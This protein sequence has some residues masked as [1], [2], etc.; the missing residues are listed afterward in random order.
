ME[1]KYTL[2]E[3][4]YL[5]FNLFHIKNS[6]TAAKSLKMQRFIT[7][8]VYIVLAFVFSKM[9][10][11]PLLYTLIPFAIVGVLWIIFYPK[12][13]YRVVVRQTKKMI[14]EGKNEGLLGSHT[15]FLNDEGIR[16]TNA[17]GETKVNWS[18]ILHLKEDHDNLYVYNSSVSAYIL[19][20][21]ELGNHEEFKK[22]IHTK[23]SE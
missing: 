12:Y 15:M 6:D 2:T 7:P 17:T 3:E 19:P 18:G 9:M 20:K 10:D 14:K 5:K 16:D 22:Y 21:R 23:L 8:F 4:D 13:F 11:V 1:I